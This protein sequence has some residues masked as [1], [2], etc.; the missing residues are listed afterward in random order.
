MPPTEWI[1]CDSCL[2]DEAQ[3]KGREKIIQIIESDLTEYGNLV[4]LAL[5]S[6][7]RIL[8]MK[9]RNDTHT[10]SVWS[11]VRVCS[12]YCEDK[13]LRRR[14]EEKPSRIRAQQGEDELDDLE[15]V[16]EEKDTEK[17]KE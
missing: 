8:M 2:D 17:G 9:P 14:L 16:F 7:G 4:L 11:E 15:K 12:C 13:A 3:L 10:G 6:E 1:E 5:T